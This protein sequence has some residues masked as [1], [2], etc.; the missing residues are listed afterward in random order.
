MTQPPEPQP[1]Q[2]Q[3]PQYPPQG[4]PYP[5][6]QQP[7]PPQQP[8]SPPQQPPNGPQQPWYPPQQP[9]KKS[10]TWLWVLLTI[11][12]IMVLG[13]GGC[14]AV[15]G[16]VLN[17]AD[18]SLNH[19]NNKKGGHNHPITIT[20]GQAFTIGQE[21]YHS[22]WRLKTDFGSAGVANLSV[23]NNGHDNDFPSVTFEMWK[24]TTMLASV[25]CGLLEEA[26]PGTTQKLDCSGDQ[27]LPQHYEKLTVRNAY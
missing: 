23:T 8:P 6:Q 18:K 27:R 2:P 5:A 9:P 16:G 13:C 17:S 25:D 11:G 3:Q 7:Y 15:V 12:V 4:Q 19:H 22:G 1:N 21:Q 10:R 20:E 24:G 14:L 26:P